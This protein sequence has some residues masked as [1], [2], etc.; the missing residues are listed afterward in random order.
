MYWIKNLLTI[1]YLIIEE[2][3]TVIAEKMLILISID[4][5]LWYMYFFHNCLFE[6][7][8]SSISGLLLL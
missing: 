2:D 8:L 7:L 6:V 1:Y 4:S 3:L 5:T